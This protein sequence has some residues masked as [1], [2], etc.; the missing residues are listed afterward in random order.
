MNPKKAF[1][2][3]MSKGSEKRRKAREEDMDSKGLC[4][5]IVLLIPK[6]LVYVFLLVIFGSFAAM[7]YITYTEKNLTEFLVYDRA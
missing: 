1:K 4:M 5:K 3:F 7:T 6:N 2:K